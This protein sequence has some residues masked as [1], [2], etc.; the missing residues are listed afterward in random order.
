MQATEVG[1]VFRVPAGSGERYDVI[2]ELITFKVT[3]TES[4]GAST[5]VE[6]LAQPGGGPPLHTHPS[7]ETFT[8]L[9]GAFEFTRLVDGVPETIRATPG[10]TVYV[11]SG[12]AH[13]YTVAGDRPGRTVLVFTPGADMEGFFEEAGS[14][15]TG[16][17]LPPP[18]AP[19]IP[20]MIAIARKH[21]MEFV[22]VAA[23]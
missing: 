19:D 21:G 11:P 15:V 13:T 9:D 12:V 22:P 18:A 7:S 16:E 1:N 6:M 20:A 17:Q 5:V 2:G 23:H 3:Q 4:H 8:I 14:L 10:D